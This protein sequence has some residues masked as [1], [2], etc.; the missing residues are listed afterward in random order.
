MVQRYLENI[1][2]TQLSILNMPLYII[3]FV[4]DKQIYI[5]KKDNQE[6]GRVWRDKK[7]ESEGEIRKTLSSVPEQVQESETT[8]KGFF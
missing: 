5:D 7:T 4:P 1:M 3:P 8:F 2:T 6:I